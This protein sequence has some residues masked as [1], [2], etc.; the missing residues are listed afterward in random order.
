MK[1][2]ESREKE[3][4]VLSLSG[5][6][7]CTFRGRLE[8]GEKLSSAGTVATATQ[9]QRHTKIIGCAFRR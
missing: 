8:K 5:R 2:D 6:H 3:E 4:L 1:T 9:C 7:S